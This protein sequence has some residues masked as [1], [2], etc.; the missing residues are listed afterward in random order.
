MLV[1]IWIQ[2]VKG[3]SQDFCTGGSHVKKRGG[4]SLLILPGGGVS[5]LILPHFS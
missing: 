1:L 3:Q 5:L 4:I 2:T